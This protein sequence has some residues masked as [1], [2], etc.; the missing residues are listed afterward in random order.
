MARRPITGERPRSPIRCAVYTRKSSEEGLEQAFNSLDTQREA[1]EAYIVSQRHE[2]WTLVKTAYDDGGFSGGSMER[3]AL[4]RLLAD[5]EAGKVDVIVV[6][7][8]DRLTRALSDFARIVEI[9]DARGASFVSVTQAFNT[10][11]SMGRLTLN[12]LLS[13]AQFEREVTGERIRDKIAASKK[14]GMWMGGNPP[15]GYDVVDRALAINEAEAAQVRHIMARYVA[16]GTTR[17]LAEELARD[18]YRTKHLHG[19]GG[20]PFSRG[21]LCHLLGNPI[22]RGK[23]THKGTVYD[24]QHQAIV[25]DALWDQVQALLTERRNNLGHTRA[26]RPSLLAGRIQDGE[27]RR[28]TPS[29]TS[30]G[31]KRYRYYVTHPGALTAAGAIAWR[32]SAPEAERIVID[33]LKG[34]LSDRSILLTLAGAQAAPAAFAKAQQAATDLDKPDRRLSVIEQ[35][36][37]RVAIGEDRIILTLDHTGVQQ[38]LG[39]KQLT[40]DDDI[41]LTAH[42]IRIR[43]G[44]DVRLIVRDAQDRSAGTINQPLVALIAEA[45]AVHQALLVAPN[46]S[47]TS[48]AASLG[49]CRKRTAQLL[50]IALLAPDIVAHC[51]AGTQPASLTTRALLKTDLPISWQQQRARLGF[52]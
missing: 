35:L 19:R 20:I 11:S 2:G 31:G 3:P 38:R 52:A 37:G 50:R 44:K 25:D 49:K 42:M 32:I 27:G 40:S 36:I 16:L 4:Q 51:I 28:M 21:A 12:V 17:A 7:K 10:T 34:W 29:H 41:R 45:H 9:L 18:G 48:L 13:F 8:V 30:K 43:Q 5:V 33:R 39:V 46:H 22:Y 26:P 1:C 6:Y 14:K 23:V 15:L 24:G 47:I